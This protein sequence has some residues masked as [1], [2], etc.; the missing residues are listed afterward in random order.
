MNIIYQWCIVFFHG[1]FEGVELYSVERWVNFI[2]EGPDNAYLLINNLSIENS[3]K[4]KVT[5]EGEEYKHLT[6]VENIHE[7]IN[8]LCAKG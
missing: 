2:T 5:L 7:S 3:S 6:P 8:V 4:T 1:C